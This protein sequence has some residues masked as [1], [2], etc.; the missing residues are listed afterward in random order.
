MAYEQ[1][2]DSGSL[3]PNTR[4]REGKQDAQYQGSA[5][6]GGVNYWVDCWEN[7]PGK[8]PTFGLRFRRKDAATASQP[9]QAYQPNPAPR[10]SA[11]PQPRTA[12]PVT[13]YDSP[14]VKPDDVPF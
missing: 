13:G 12:L 7:P 2:P 11:P 5:L 6:I 14:N 1:K 3:F 10:Q 8:G 9:R 4:M